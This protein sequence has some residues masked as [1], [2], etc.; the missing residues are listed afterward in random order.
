MTNRLSLAAAAAGIVLA[1]SPLAQEAPREGQTIEQ[2]LAALESAVATVD[3]RLARETTRPGAAAESDLSLSARITAVER[4]LERLTLDVQRA[5]RLADS[6]ARAA[7]D[8][9]RDASQARQDARDAV[10]RSR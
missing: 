7:S 2:R 3:T 4:A 10:M 6:A 5:E 8:A 1:A 9:Q